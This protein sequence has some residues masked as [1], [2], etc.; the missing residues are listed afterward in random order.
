MRP[1]IA[2]A[3]MIL[4]SNRFAKPAEREDFSDFVWLEGKSLLAEART[5]TSAIAPEFGGFVRAMDATGEWEP[6]PCLLA[7][8][9]PAGPVR[10]AV[11]EE[12]AETIDKHLR[13]AG[14]LDAVYLCNHGAMVAEHL[15]DP[16]G[17][18]LSRVRNRIGSEPLIIMTLDLHAN[19]SK[20]MAMNA[21]LIVGYRTNPHV[22]MI[23]RGEEAAFSL[24]RAIA[25]I[26]NGERPKLR[27]VK[28]PISPASV[29]LLTAQGPFAD[30]IDFGQ[31]RQAELGAEILNVS[32]F[33]NFIFSDTPDNTLT[34]VVTARADESAA[35]L[36]ANEIGKLAWS[37]KERF[38][39]TLMPVNEAVDLAMSNNRQPVI[40]SDAGDNPGGGGSGKTTE[41][42]KALHHSG[43]SRIFYGSFFDPALATKAHEIGVGGSFVAEFNSENSLE[44][45]GQPWRAWDIPFSAEAE[46]LK[47]GDGDVV[48]LGG[49]TKGRRLKL[50]K[51]AALRIGG[52]IV[53]VISDRAQ[54]ADPVYFDMFD[55]DIASAHTVIVKSRGHFRAGFAP[56]FSPE[57][58]YEIDTGGLTSPVL[59]R[60]PFKY[61][62]RP[63]FPL[64]TDTTWS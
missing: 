49:L 59:E 47:L 37:M 16:D 11:F 18:L 35:E 25:G 21:D 60:W 36:L 38:Q 42:L 7:A 39:R 15:H 22:D 19:I 56:W 44:D 17:E 61:I 53:I 51:T 6:I 48:G 12:I 64:D 4:E 34:A 63:T 14:P 31:R 13:E 46:V 29:T 10:E 54:T 58:V 55:L 2:L 40:F 3:G 23:E 43:A 28:P 62:P 26:E 8:S 1:R 32:I 41:L 27:I 5:K 45:S 33:G 50:G 57:Q 9:H 20:Q 24:R 52:I 30:L